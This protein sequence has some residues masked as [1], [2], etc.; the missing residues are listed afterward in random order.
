MAR[1]NTP[2]HSDDGFDVLYN[3]RDGS[4]VGGGSADLHESASPSANAGSGPHEVPQ[5]PQA[6]EHDLADELSK[7]GIEHFDPDN[8]PQI[9]Q[10]DAHDTFVDDFA[11]D[12]GD[13]SLQGFANFDQRAERAKGE[14]SGNLV[15]DRLKYTKTFCDKWASKA[16]L[17]GKDTRM[18]KDAWIAVMG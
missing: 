8:Q 6:D 1:I 2:V 16:A 12:L 13:L 15:D 11:P 4:D 18:G 5:T 10:A 9:P 14:Q 17:M 7:Q 3:V